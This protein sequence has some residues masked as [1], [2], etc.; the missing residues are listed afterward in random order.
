MGVKPVRRAL[1]L[2]EQGAQLSGGEK[3]RVALAWLLVADP[4]IVL[5]DEFSSALDHQTMVDVARNLRPILAGRTVICV[6]P[7]DAVLP[8]IGIQRPADCDVAG[9]IGSDTTT[10]W[11]AER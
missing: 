9:R 6:A 10:H 8:E 7:H 4:S 5:L 2:G 1:P 3:Q 11:A